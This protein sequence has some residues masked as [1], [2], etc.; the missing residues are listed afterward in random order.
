MCDPL[1]SRMVQEGIDA[2]LA[3]ARI[4]HP[5]RHPTLEHSF[6]VLQEEVEELKDELKKGGHIDR[7]HMAILIEAR[8]VGAMARRLLEDWADLPTQEEIT[9]YNRLKKADKEDS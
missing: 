4:K 1:K 2:E 9:E 5:D 6:F 8:Q 7:D 3:K